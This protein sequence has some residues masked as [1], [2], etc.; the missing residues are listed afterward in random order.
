[1]YT[2]NFNLVLTSMDIYIYGYTHTYTMLTNKSN[3]F[4]F[5]YIYKLNA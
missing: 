3:V 2:S 5:H 1:M 4:M